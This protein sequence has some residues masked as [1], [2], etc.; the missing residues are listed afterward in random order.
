MR[1]PHRLLKLG[2]LLLAVFLGAA[3]GCQDK[4]PTPVGTP[5]PIVEVARPKEM[6]VTDFQVFVAR[7]A[8]EYSVDVKPRVTGFLT[9][10]RFKDGDTVQKDQVLFVIDKRP[11]KND[12]DLATADVE[13]AD[14][15]AKLAKDLYDI[16]LAVYKT[17]KTAIS[18]ARLAKSKDTWGQALAAIDQAKAKQE[19]AKLNYDW[20]EVTSPITGLANRHFIDV[21]NIV[22]KDTSTLTNIVSLKP[23]W[24]YFDV[25]ENTALKVQK[26]IQEGKLASARQPTMT[27]DR[28]VW[29]F[30]DVWS[31]VA[32][33]WPTSTRVE[34]ALSNSKGFPYNGHID[35]V[36]NQLDPNTGSIRVRA[37]FRNEDGTLQ[38]GLFG[39][40]RVPISADHPA[41]LVSDQ[42]VGTNQGQKYVLVVNDRDQVEYRAV[43]VGQLQNGLREVMRFRTIIE[44]GAD[45]KDQ[46]RE[47][48]V[49][50]PTDRII[51]DGLQRVRPGAKV[52]PRLVDMETLLLDSGK[53][54]AP[55][56]KD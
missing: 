23:T 12:L 5:P 26:L 50:W 46:R 1:F 31:F 54:K 45:G 6:E 53:P 47:V 10:I 39:R 44:T 51:V 32:A 24:A 25:D 28:A 27:V 56:K 22:G 8:A 13:Y 2:S 7:T 15:T 36:S 4:H 18:Q 33:T 21:G 9:E 40:V 11:Y 52:D 3:G 55:G 20:C 41:L 29:S 14:A 34:M 35:F 49:L 38:A 17:D 43:D 19:Q 48:Q 16:D 37:V 30:A 42:A